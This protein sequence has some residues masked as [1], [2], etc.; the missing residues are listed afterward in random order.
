MASNAAQAKA[1]LESLASGRFKNLSGA[2]LKLLRA[3]PSG[4]LAICGLNIVDGDPLNDPS[5]AGEWGE[6][7]HIRAD[8]I[9]WLCASR[10]SREMVDP[11]G[12]RVYGAKISGQ[13]NL[14]FMS[15]PFPLIFLHCRLL[16]DTNL[17]CTELP[18]LVL[19]GT[20]VRSLRAS[21]AKV[22][23]SVLLNEGFRAQ[24]VVSLMM[25]QING[26][27]DCVRAKFENSAKTGDAE[28]GIALNAERARV[29]GSLFLRNGFS[30]EGS[31]RFLNAQ[32][33]GDFDCS[34]RTFSNPFQA[35]I[36]GT[37]LALNASRCSVGGNV[38]LNNGFRAAGMVSL[39]GAH[40]AGSL[41]CGKG[42]FENP[43]QPGTSEPT[44][45]LTV[46]GADVKGSVL[47]DIGFSALGSVRLRGIQVGGN[48]GCRGASFKA[49]PQPGVSEHRAAA[50]NFDGIA[51]EGSLFLDDGFAADGGVRIV[52]A[53]IGGDLQ[54]EK[55]T[56]NNPSQP[57]VPGSGTAINADGA[58]VKGRC[59][60]RNGFQA[61]GTVRFVTARIGKDFECRGA[62]LGDGLLAARMTVG[63]NFF[64]KRIVD[65]DRSK[66]ELG[67]A[68]VSAFDDDE[69]SY[70]AQGNLNL[71]GFVYRRISR[72]PTGAKGR[73]RWLALQHSFAPQP[74]RQLAKVLRAEGDDAGARRVLCEMEQLRRS[75]ENSGRSPIARFL[76]SVW[77]AVL[78][79]TIGYG[80]HPGRSLL[81]LTILV[82]LGAAVFGI[83]YAAGSIAPTE[84]ESYSK[85]KQSGELPPNHNRFNPIVFSLENAFPLIKLG[86][87]DYW[88][89]DPD[90]NWK[91]RPKSW[92]P[93]FLY[94][95]LSP[96]CLRR[97]RWLETCLGWFFA[98]MGVAAVSGIA[99]RD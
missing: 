68:S 40:V 20:W 64:W 7:R 8:L 73:L 21:T 28:S 24:G 34:Q 93:R 16:D 90:K 6:E 72:N 29:G 71:D 58:T 59:F 9:R 45:A 89:T 57:G 98:T 62:K 2:E 13:L 61:D 39:A 77:S 35:G 76:G 87:A 84:R 37:G 81:C 49:P 66:L 41:W 25:A 88:Q 15:I 85:F 19:R 17:H 97:I 80:F 23:G 4:K 55:G 12:I 5:K 75:Y 63:G 79:G 74:Y 27:L 46:E 32:I 22:S 52:G 48:M 91:S 92:V 44:P 82:L 47:L 42:T 50:L 51:L 60:L 95:T 26:D 36:A 78:R 14:A 30:S 53:E 83:G 11:I 31:V 10:D 96:W 86:Q 1:N 3:T 65:P 99:R 70:P 67:D 56:F 69:K 94:W 54:T 18:E 38:I 43:F 33:G